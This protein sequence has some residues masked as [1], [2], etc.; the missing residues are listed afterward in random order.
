MDVDCKQ[1]HMKFYLFLLFNVYGIMSLAI[2]RNGPERADAIKKI[3]VK[4]EA[5]PPG[6]HFVTIDEAKA[7]AKPVQKPVPK[8][9]GQLEKIWR[10]ISPEAS[11][12]AG[13]VADKVDDA[14][15]IPA[16]TVAVG[17]KVAGPVEKAATK[18]VLAVAEK[19]GQ[20]VAGEVAVKG[21]AAVA[22]GLILAEPVGDAVAI[23]AGVVWDARQLQKHKHQK[24]MDELHKKMKF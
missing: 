18:G 12:K 13:K 24:D 19:T 15:F 21:L 20:K 23:A 1:A 11:T 4:R 22:G 6:P 2:G 8:Q 14:V 10:K 5:V 3:L 17:A 16:K 9:P 7:T